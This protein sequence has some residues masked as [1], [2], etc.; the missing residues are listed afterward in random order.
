MT[1]L[2]IVQQKLVRLLQTLNREVR[3][4]KMVVQYNEN[5][6][7][8]GTLNMQLRK[9]DVKVEVKLALRAN[10]GPILKFQT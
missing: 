6:G 5:F 2:L 3:I 10:C 7:I 9:R 1:C 8:T 4:L